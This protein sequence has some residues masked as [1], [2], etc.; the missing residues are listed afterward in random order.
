MPPSGGCPSPDIHTLPSGTPLWRIH[1]DHFDPAELNLASPAPFAGG[2]F[3]CTDGTYSYL[4]AGSDS[5]AA[6]AE[7]LLRDR[8]PNGPYWILRKSLVGKRLSKL[9]LATALRVAVLHGAGLTAIR[10]KAD[11]TSSG[12]DEYDKTRAG[13]VSLRA[14]APSSCGF[15]WRPRHDNDR[16]AYVFFGD[17]CASSDFVVE[18][19]YSLQEGRGRSLLNRALALHGAVVSP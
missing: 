5:I 11:L 8:P 14:S 10:Q 19:S 15:E 16:F 7:T 17:R 3:D 2:R 18:R 1:S 6:V 13:G 12:P 4:Y 9:S